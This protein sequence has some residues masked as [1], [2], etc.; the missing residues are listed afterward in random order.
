[1][2]DFFSEPYL[3]WHALLAIVKGVEAVRHP[4]PILKPL[5]IGAAL[6]ILIAITQNILLKTLSREDYDR[7][8]QHFGVTLFYALLIYL[9]YAF[10][11]GYSRAKKQNP[12]KNHQGEP[13][14][15][16]LQHDSPLLP[17][18][19]KYPYLKKGCIGILIV[20]G[21]FYFLFLAVS[22]SG[23]PKLQHANSVPTPTAEEA[24]KPPEKIN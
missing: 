18:K 19:K 2:K 17:E 9:V 15:K 10:C 14:E 20:L 23:G 21:I 4:R 3:M 22:L 12:P 13:T 11:K 6:G 7:V 1:M 8:V 5:L 24:K 16:Y